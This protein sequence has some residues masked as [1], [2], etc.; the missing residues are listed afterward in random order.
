MRGKP[1]SITPSHPS[2]CS[3]CQRV[4]CFGK[5]VR[6]EMGKLK[7][8]NMVTAAVNLFCLE[9]IQSPWKVVPVLT[10]CWNSMTSLLASLAFHQNNLGSPH[11]HSD[12]SL[13]FW[14]SFHFLKYGSVKKGRLGLNSLQSTIISSFIGQTRPHEDWVRPCFPQR[15][16]ILSA[17]NWAC[18]I[19]LLPLIL[20]LRIY[21]YVHSEFPRMLSLWL[22]AQFTLSTTSPVVAAGWVMFQLGSLKV[23]L[24]P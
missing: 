17:V 22:T 6:C 15:L 8:L 18:R 5:T 4:I 19:F 14:N 7:C 11:W 21:I 10:A 9:T 1:G 23:P 3:V 20:K 24:G 2:A 16:L 12:Y 13:R